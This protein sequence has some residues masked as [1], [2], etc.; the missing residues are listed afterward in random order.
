MRFGALCRAAVG[1]CLPVLA[2]AQGAD[3]GMHPGAT[4]K[5]GGAERQVLR[6]NDFG[7][8]SMAPPSDYRGFA[9]NRT[10]LRGFSNESA[11]RNG[12]RDFGYLGAESD[13]AEEGVEVYKGPASALY[14]NGK[15]GGDIN[16]LVRLPDGQRRR[17]AELSV[18]RYG[19]RSLRAEIGDA[20]PTPQNGRPK[21]VWRLGLGVDAGGSRRQFDD[22]ESYGISP[23]IAW[24]LGPRTRVTLEADAVWLRD[25]TQPTRL[26]LAPLIAFSERRTLGE[27][28]DWYRESGST[29]RAALEHLINARWRLRQ[30]VFVQ[31]SRAATDSAELDVYGLTGPEVI[32]EDG[33]AVRRVSLRL[34]ERIRSEV[35]QTELYGNVD[36]LGASHRLLL[37]LELSRHR[38]DTTDARAPLA[39]LNLHAPVYG[40]QPGPFSNNIDQAERSRNAAVVLQDRVQLAARWQALLGVRAERMRAASDD[41]LQGAAQ[42]GRSNLLSPRLGLVYTPVPALSWFASWTQSSRPQWGEVTADGSL[43][44]PEQGRQVEAGLQWRSERGLVGTLS[45]YRLMRHQLATT[46]TRNPSYSVAGGERRSQGIELELRGELT[47]GTQLDLSAELLRTRVVRDSEV[48]AGAALPGVAPWFAGLWLTQRLGDRW[49]LGWGLVG[50]GR[51]RAAWAPNELRLP[52]Y[53]TTDL[54]LAWRR[55]GWRVQVGMGNALGRRALLSDGYAVRVMQPRSLSLTASFEVS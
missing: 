45:L 47:P 35:S 15:P 4:F 11:L 20:D 2:T 22:F 31:R 7:A 5:E 23:S 48:P 24:Y 52:A 12:Y 21:M 53:V 26:P 3:A 54:S 28:S 40:A 32:T 6:F 38:L 27:P 34:H 1:L 46:D 13:T 16:R 42:R 18:D 49:T 29:V 10:L 36:A 30:A 50:E 51:R 33:Q 17:D 55:P 8:Q 14:G 41:R 19:Y 44:P 39:E 25:Q 37:G 9:V 43:L